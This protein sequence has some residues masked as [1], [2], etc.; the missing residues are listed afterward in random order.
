MPPTAARQTHPKRPIVV[1]S[2]DGTNVDDEWPI[3]LGCPI[4]SQSYHTEF[5]VKLPAGAGGLAKKGWVRVPLVQPFAKAD[6][7]ERSGQLDAGV[8]DEIIA[9]LLNYSGAIP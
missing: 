4:S 3:F 7:M 5:D 9:R 8:M 6:V 2:A 1:M